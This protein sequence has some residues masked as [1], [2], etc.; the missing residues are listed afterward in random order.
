[1]SDKPQIVVVKW[2]LWSLLGWSNVLLGMIGIAPA[3][4]GK[5]DYFI[6]GSV[7]SLI[8]GGILI[9]TN[10]PVRS[11]SIHQITLKRLETEK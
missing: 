1:M 8:A 6:W 10:G 7:I 2:N 4:F 11:K 3:V 5:T 9:T